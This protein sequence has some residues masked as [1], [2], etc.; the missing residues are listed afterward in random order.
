MWLVSMFVI[1]VSLEF[2]GKLNQ[3]QTV[4]RFIRLRDQKVFEVRAIF[5]VEQSRLWD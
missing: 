2:N 3:N 5:V 4:T 1:S